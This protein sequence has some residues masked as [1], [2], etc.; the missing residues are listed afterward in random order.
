ML[1][2]NINDDLQLLV[3][4]TNDSL[5]PYSSFYQT[6]VAW[7]SVIHRV[8]HPSNEMAIFC[9]S[10]N[11]NFTS[12]LIASAINRCF[13]HWRFDW[14]YF[15]NLWAAA[16]HNLFYSKLLY[17]SDSHGNTRFH[18]LCQWAEFNLL[19]LNLCQLF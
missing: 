16:Y 19:V 8:A 9:C 17:F 12:I 6:N 3:M 11:L 14:L 13:F 1:G 7:A 2:K 15:P 5:R 18:R 10:P 4:S